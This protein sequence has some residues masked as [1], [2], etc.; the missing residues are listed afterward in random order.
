MIDQRAFIELNAE[1]DQKVRMKE[2]L[3]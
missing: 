2:N 3:T 1:I